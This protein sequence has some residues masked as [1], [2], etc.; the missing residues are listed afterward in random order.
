M[1]RYHAG[2]IEEAA[3][4]AGEEETLLARKAVVDNAG[5]LLGALDTAHHALDGD[6]DGDML[7]AV[8]LL[9]EAADALAGI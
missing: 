3:L 7:G 1:L 9:T 5:R 6:E 4:Q 8:G 2:E